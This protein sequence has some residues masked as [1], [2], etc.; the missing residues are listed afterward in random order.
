MFILYAIGFAIIVTC[1]LLLTRKL[2][3]SYIKNDKLDTAEKM[4]G[5]NKGVHKTVSQWTRI[6]KDASVR[7]LARSQ[8]AIPAK[9]LNTIFWTGAEAML[10]QYDPTK[11]ICNETRKEIDGLLRFICLLRKKTNHSAVLDFYDNLEKDALEKY[12]TAE[13][14]R[15]IRDIFETLKFISATKSD[16]EA[17]SELSDE[18]VA[19]NTSQNYYQ[20]FGIRKNASAEA[21]KKAYRT[22]AQKHHPDRNPADA[23]GEMF[24]RINMI[25]QVLKDPIK[26][27]EYDDSL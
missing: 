26:R 13:N 25:Y 27:R 7:S 11:V 20:T 3:W 9:F 4:H 5:F 21:I 14:V 16:A 12:D 15:N 22:L 1:V 10:G 17:A 2:V 18:D 19:V 24:K 23:T 6:G 8:T